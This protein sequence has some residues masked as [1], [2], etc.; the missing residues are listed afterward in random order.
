[1]SKGVHYGE[2]AEVRSGSAYFGNDKMSQNAS[3]EMGDS[4]VRR[5]ASKND[6]A[7]VESHMTTEESFCGDSTEYSRAAIREF[8]DHF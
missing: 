6:D 2:Q 3:M 4:P 7:V 5:Q 8:Q 1:M